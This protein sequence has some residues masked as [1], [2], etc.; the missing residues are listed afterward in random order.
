MDGMLCRGKRRNGAGWIEGYPVI[1]E[2][3]INPGSVHICPS[4]YA[5]RVYEDGSLL[6]GGFVGVVPETV[7]RYIGKL[8]K[9]GKQIFDKDIVKH[10]N[11]AE[12]PEHFVIH[13]VEWDAK[14]FRWSMRDPWTGECY[15]VGDQC[16]YEVIG[17]TIDNP[18]LLKREP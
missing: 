9:N 15:T 7:G 5:G 2:K 18:E 11:W 6:L 14:R 16:T 4:V 13:V 8:D 12:F 1:S 17:N 10:Y 3:I